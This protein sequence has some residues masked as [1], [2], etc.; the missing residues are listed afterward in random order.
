MK[1]YDVFV[2]TF[3]ENELN[4]SYKPG[5]PAAIFDRRYVGSVKAESKDMA[6]RYFT[7]DPAGYSAI[8]V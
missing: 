1:M 6:I 7:A 2:M 3:D 5:N 4:E 8:L